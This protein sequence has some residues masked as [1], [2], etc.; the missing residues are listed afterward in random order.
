MHFARKRWQFCRT[1]ASVVLPRL[2]EGCGQRA[3]AG[4]FCVGSG[5][6]VFQMFA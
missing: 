4:H 6:L 5:A 3:R 1:Y 2:I